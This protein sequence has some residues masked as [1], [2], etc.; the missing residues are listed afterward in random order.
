M[1]SRFKRTVSVLLVV[2]MLA[3]LMPV[4]ALADGN[5]FVLSV[6]PYGN[7]QDSIDTIKWFKSDLGYYLFLPADCDRSALTVYFTGDKKVTV[8]GKEIKN[9][10]TTNVFAKGSIFTVKCGYDIYTLTVMSS[11]NVPAVYMSTESG[12]L[13]YIHADKS[14]KEKGSIRIYE[15]GAEA[16]SG[17]LKQ[18]KGRGNATWDNEKKPYNIKFDKKTSI[19]GMEKAKKWT[20]LANYD[21]PSIVR[22]PLAWY[23]SDAA[24]LYY[25]SDYRIVDLYINNE[26][27]GNYII[28]ESVEI[29]SSR[30]DINDLAGKTEDVNSEDLED[31]PLGGTQSAYVFPSQK[32]VDIPNNPKD[33]TGGYLLECEINYRYGDEVSGF[34][35]EKGQCVVVKEPEYASQAQVEYISSYWQD[36]EDALYSPDG[37]NDKGIHYSEYFDM[38][39]LVNMYILGEFTNNVDTGVTSCYFYKDTNG[40]LVASPVW[41]F[42]HALGYSTTRMG[43]DYAS[44]DIWTANRFDYNWLGTVGEYEAP[45]V[46]NLLYRHEDFREL[47][48]ARWPQLA[49]S[50]GGTPA[51]NFIKGLAKEIKASAVM[52]GVRWYGFYTETLYT[53]DV[54]KV[55][56]FVSARKCGLNKGFGKNAAQLYYDVNGGKGWMFDNLIYANGDMASVK[57]HVYDHAEVKAPNSNYIFAGWNTKPDGSGKTYLPGSLIRLSG[58]V[59]L[60]AQWKLK[61]GVKA[62]TPAGAA[63]FSDI[64]KAAHSVINNDVVNTAN[65]LGVRALNS[66]NW[67]FRLK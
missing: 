32:W 29:G 53:N 13:D 41:D 24:G 67:I 56:S 62:D 18:I 21:D 9:G 39:A 61:P 33:I 47:V 27:M 44:P 40:K 10:E 28:C 58:V 65:Q 66:F 14:N 48:K 64:E 43:S 22:N 52:N 11:E 34:V 57:S 51:V 20:L 38:D 3:A 16:F 7:E 63:E 49:E 46:F 60:Y 2:L 1:H 54:T 55:T 23:L 8:L 30:V 31:Y 19:L 36:A 4:A 6:N 17:D 15:D 50:F 5:K 37:C 26:Y 45:T 12:S 35:T 25:R 42:D 59:T